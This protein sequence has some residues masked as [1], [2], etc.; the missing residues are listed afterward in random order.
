MGEDVNMRKP[1]GPQPVPIH[2]TH[3]QLSILQ[4]I[5][6]YRRSPQCEALRANIIIYANS[7]A[8]NEQIAKD[9]GIE[10]QTARLWRQRWA[11]N[12]EKFRQI[13]A[14]D[15]DKTLAAS[16]RDV[17]AD[18]PRSGCPPTFIPDQVC[19]IVA[20]ACTPPADSGRPI[21]N[22]TARELADEAVKRN[23]VLSISPRSI[24]RF[25]SKRRPHP[26]QG[27]ILAQQ[28]TRQGS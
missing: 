22:W 2:L 9:L 4:E 6:R 21:T 23:I 24:G 15:D 8:R 12:A 26:A 19:M 27:P 25:F 20:L 18:E 11:K 5:Q 13:E 3:K 14:S 10:R 16:I 28:R 7:G 1:R 17:L